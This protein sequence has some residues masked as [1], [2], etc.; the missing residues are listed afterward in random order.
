MY[1]NYIF[2]LYGT[3]ADIRTNEE[4]PYLWQKMSEFY[5]SLGAP[6]SPAQLRREFRRLEQEAAGRV[7][8]EA[9][10]F[11]LR[12]VLAEPD[13]TGVFQRLFQEKG[14]ACE[15]QTARMA[16]IFFRTLSRQLIQV[17]DGVKETL[18]EL[19]VRG[20]GL[21]LLSNAQSDFTRPELELLGLA[22]SFNGILI[23]SEE[24]CKKPCSAFFRRL[25]ERYNLEPARCLMVGNDMESD[26]AGAADVGMDSLY[27]HTATSPRPEGRYKPTYCVTDGDWTKVADILLGG[28]RTDQCRCAQACRC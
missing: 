8:R 10:S 14:V 9:A 12:D 27:L 6:Y 17:Y 21:Y 13:L 5:T 1:D 20:R 25:L 11:G 22:G 15:R 7:Q 2:D 3:L 26:I 24:G 4:K 23:S 18:Q 19:H 28:K 16:A